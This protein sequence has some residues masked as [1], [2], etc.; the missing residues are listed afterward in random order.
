MQLHE[1]RPIHKQKRRKR[2][3]RGGKKGTYAG[4][5]MKG[6][7]ARAGVRMKP[8]IR[9]LLKRYPKLR[10]YRFAGKAKGITVVNL[11][12]LE[13]QFQA[14]DLVTP[15]SLVAKNI[16]RRIQGRLPRVKI[17]GKG[18]LTKALKVS[19]CL[20]SESAKKKIKKA[21]GTIT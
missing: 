15:E 1:L 8:A 19:Q 14:Q 11:D 21:G 2:V 10:G 7:G 9:E 16:V 12:I 5:G 20:V 6:Q 17:L 18:E 13:K 4:R 3:G